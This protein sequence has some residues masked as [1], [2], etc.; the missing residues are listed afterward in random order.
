MREEKLPKMSEKE[1]LLNSLRAE[2]ARMEAK[3]VKRRK[4]GGD[5]S[6]TKNA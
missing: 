4:K 3:K 5:I 1:K 2:L 6:T